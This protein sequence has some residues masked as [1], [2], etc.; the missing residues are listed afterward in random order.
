MIHTRRQSFQPPM[1]QWTQRAAVALFT[2]LLA[3]C[4]SG[5]S[6]SSNPPSASPSPSP[7]PS[8]SLSS[9]AVTGVDVDEGTS[10]QFT[11][12]AHFSDGSNQ[13][14]TSQATW[15]SSNM[16]VATVSNGGLVTGVTAGSSDIRATYQGV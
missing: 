3:S 4:G 13:S 2:L 1:S 11:A 5:S 10:E 9:V 8:P 7:A 14:V 6:S 16:S 15:Q 12:A